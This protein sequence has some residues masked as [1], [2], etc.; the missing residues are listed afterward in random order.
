[1]TLAV[2]VLLNPNTTNQQPLLSGNTP[3]LD[4]SKILS[5]GKELTSISLF[6]TM[7]SKAFLLNPS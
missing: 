4:K 5:V 7:S 2:K 3:N 1:M 6:P